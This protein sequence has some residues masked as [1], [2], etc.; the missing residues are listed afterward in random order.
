MTAILHGGD[1][2]VEFDLR[3]GHE[4]GFVTRKI[5]AGIANI[6]GRSELLHGHLAGKLGPVLRRVGAAQYEFDQPMPVWLDGAR[7]D[8]VTSLSVRLEPDAVDIWI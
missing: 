6:S 3:T 4:S 5:D 7:T 8:P 2:A 1:A